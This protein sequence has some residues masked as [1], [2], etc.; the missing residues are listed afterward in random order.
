MVELILDFPG[1]LASSPI[2]EIIP[3]FQCLVC[4]IAIAIPVIVIVM[5]FGLFEQLFLED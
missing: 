1:Q 3:I 2:F 4:A 5:L